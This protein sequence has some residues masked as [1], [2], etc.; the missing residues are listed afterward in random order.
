MSPF[1]SP[2]TEG[3]DLKVPT[4]VAAAAAAAQKSNDGGGSGKASRHHEDGIELAIFQS[5]PVLEEEDMQAGRGSEG[6]DTSQTVQVAVRDSVVIHSPNL[7]NSR[8]VD[9]ASGASASFG[10][11]NSQ[12][13]LPKKSQGT[14]FLE[15]QFQALKE[16]LAE[17]PGSR[18]EEDDNG[19]EDDDGDEDEIV[20]E[21]EGEEEERP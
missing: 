17:H 8:I 7:D 18:D 16:N 15:K 3:H 2:Q 11:P 12:S 20:K 1:P 6:A 14:A 5:L 21:Q 9:T 4:A 13:L 19:D 10:S